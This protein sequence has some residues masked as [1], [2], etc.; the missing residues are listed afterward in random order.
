MY[1][2]LLLISAL[3]SIAVLAGTIW[4]VNK[5]PKGKTSK[6]TEEEETEKYKDIF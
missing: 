3:A 2:T 6:G 5:S 1:L 4:F